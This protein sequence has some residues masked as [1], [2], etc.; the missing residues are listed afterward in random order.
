M[1]HRAGQGRGNNIVANIEVV[2]SRPLAFS[3]RVDDVAELLAGSLRM[4][5]GDLSHDDWLQNLMRMTGADS[6]SCCAWQP[7]KPRTPN[8]IHA[9]CDIAL[10]AIW[11]EWV[12]T[13]LG[14]QSIDR[15]YAIN[16]QFALDMTGE[17]GGTRCGIDQQRHIMVLVDHAPAR[18]VFC[19]SRD[20]YSAAWGPRDHADFIAFA[21]HIRSSCLLHKHVDGLKN[22]GLISNSVFNSS[23]RGMLLLQ[24]DGSVPIA[25]YK[26]QQFTTQADGLSIRKGKLKIKDPE[27]MQELTDILVTLKQIPKT[28]LHKMRWFWSVSGP[29]R[30]VPYQLALQI[31]ALPDWHIESADTDRYALLFINDPTSLG[32]PSTAELRKFYGFTPAQARLALALWGGMGIQGAADEL[33]ISINTARSH[34]RSIYAT[35]GTHS[36]AELMSVL[37]ATMIRNESGPRPFEPG[38]P[39]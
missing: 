11:Q 15:P 17:N 25:N 3:Y 31:V 13:I 32:R 12:E 35:T 1:Q 7:D 37:T 39:N 36:H 6:A 10:P 21:G 16:D 18:T 8:F 22:I 5:R 38:R 26:A 29:N 27:V 28:K 14:D 34:L 24:S 20:T 2:G 33:C 9:G 23:P 30:E 4:L 19:V